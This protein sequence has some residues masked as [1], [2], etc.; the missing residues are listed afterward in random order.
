MLLRPRKS[1]DCRGSQARLRRGIGDPVPLW[2][3]RFKSGPFH[4]ENLR[5]KANGAI[6]R[7]LG[8]PASV[9]EARQD[10]AAAKFKG[11]FVFFFRS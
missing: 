1:Y 4:P 11:I 3:R 5:V 6:L 8:E 10:P 7:M 2:E 9:G